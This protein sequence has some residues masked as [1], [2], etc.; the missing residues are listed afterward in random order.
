MSKIG[1]SA[2][3]I[4]GIL[5]SIFC[6]LLSF[7]LSSNLLEKKSEIK[8]DKADDLIVDERLI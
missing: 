7:S 3:L 8:T 2:A 5:L 6:L 4:S 1:L